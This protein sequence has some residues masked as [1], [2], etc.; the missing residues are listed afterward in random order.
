VLLEL[1][2][3]AAVGDDGVAAIEQQFSEPLRLR[4]WGRNLGGHPISGPVYE[5]CRS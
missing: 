3:V 4:A 1:G 2:V 5:A